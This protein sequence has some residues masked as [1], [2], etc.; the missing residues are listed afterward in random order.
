MPCPCA[1]THESRRVVLTGGPGAGKTAVLEMVRNALCRH[2]RVLPEAAGV[3]F[4]GGFRVIASLLAD[5]PDSAPYSTCNGSWRSPA[6]HTMLRWSSATAGRLMDWP[7]SPE[8]RWASTGTTLEAE[9]ARY[10]AVIYL[11]TPETSHGHNWDDHP[12]RTEP[13]QPQP[14]RSTSASSKRGNSILGRYVIG[15]HQDFIDKAAATLTTL[16]RELPDCCAQHLASAMRTGL[17]R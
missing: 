7:G 2:I 14:L 6:T 16:H 12:L 15:A 9:I 17:S 13:R 8:D 4:G 10:D 1:E 11:R 5:G 3:V